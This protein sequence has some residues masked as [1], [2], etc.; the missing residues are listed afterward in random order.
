MSFFRLEKDLTQPQSALP[1]E[2]IIGKLNFDTNVGN[3][4]PSGFEKYVR[5]L[6]SGYVENDENSSDGYLLVQ[7]RKIGEWS[8]KE[9]VATSHIRDVMFREDGHWWNETGNGPSQGELE[10]TQL[11]SLL[12]ILAKETATPGEIWML[13]WSGYGGDPDTIGL[14][15]EIND[16][17][18]ESGREYVLRQ[19]KIVTVENEVVFPNFEHPPSFWW[20][21]DRAWFVSCDID[22]SSTYVGGSTELIE[23]ILNDLTLETFQVNLDDPHQGLYIENPI[24]EYEIQ[25]TPWTTHLRHFGYG[26]TYRLDRKSRSSVSLYKQKIWR[27]WLLRWKR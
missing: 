7:W 18:T 6:H 25:T 16:S 19:G 24:S 15:C 12:D 13:I 3:W 27:E 9:I 4:I 1:V 5:I 20:P 26:F 14:P 23:K 21:R 2:W 17:F 22:S 11:N 10:K 8:G